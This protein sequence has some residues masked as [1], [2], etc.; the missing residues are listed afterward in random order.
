[1]ARILN[2]LSWALLAATG[3][4]LAGAGIL[5]FLLNR[6]LPDYDSSHAVQG[7][8]GPVEIVRDRHAI[9][10]IFGGTD[11]DVFFGLGFAHAQDRLWQMTLLRR[12]AH[13][14]LSEI[15][16]P[17]TLKTDRLMRMLDIHGLSVG[18]LEY[19]TGEARAALNAYSRGVN[20]W[21]RILEDRFLN[22]GAPEF[23]LFDST[24]RPWEPFDSIAILNL[25]AIEL[26]THAEDETLRTR[27]A[28]QLSPERMSDL[29]PADP[30][31]GLAIPFTSTV[32]GLSPVKGDGLFTQF[33]GNGF[34]GA[35]NAW[36]A[37]PSRSAD[38]TSL[39]ANDPH[40][41]LRA[42]S[43]WMLARLELSSGGVIGGTIPGVPLI[44][45]GRTA[46]TA[47]GVTSSYVDDQ[48][49]YF[50]QFDPETDTRYLTPD[51]SKEF[52]SRIEVIQIKD[53][54]PERIELKWTDNGP[55]VPEE[56]FGLVDIIPANHFASLA[57]TLLEPENRSIS[58]G[59]QLMKA[60]SVDEALEAANLHRAPT[61]NLLIADHSDIV[62]QVIGAAPRR[63][64]FHE[65]RG[66]TPSAGWK[67]HNRWQGEMSFESLPRFRNPANG[68]LANTNNKT[69]DRPF[70]DHLSL[71]WG[72]SQRIKRLEQLLATRESHTLESFTSIQLDTLSYPATT[73][74]PLFARELWHKTGI[75]PQSEIERLRN[76]A[77][78]QIS[79]W[80]GEM[81]EN[82]P[83]PLIYAAW[84]RTL[85]KLLLQDELGDLAQEFRKPDP[86]L[87]E[88][89]F[90]DVDGAA[91]L[92][93]I[94][95]TPRTESCDDISL[96]ALD[97]ALSQ[98]KERYGEELTAWRWGDAHQA[99]HDHP[100][101]GGD[102]LMSWLFSIRQSTSGGDY[103][104]NKA[105]MSGS[106]DEPYHNLHGAGYRGV[107]DFSD[108]DSSI[109]IIST[110]QSGHPLSRHFDDLGRL[111]R[112]GE[113]V[114]MS[115]D[116]DFARAN[117]IGITN[118]EPAQRNP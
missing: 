75:A 60:Q 3:L 31:T 50:E 16:G 94:V 78:E 34:R 13:G 40:L 44:A 98:L 19:Q 61:L 54:P 63:H 58:A 97:E 65:T 95:Q 114:L 6:S 38:K 46:K 5:Y 37:A 96:L 26:A 8:T 89:V 68:V 21:L 112:S 117:S 20:A 101:F 47:W 90:D 56:Y 91:E 45:I 59:I 7:I 92:C 32:A 17:A 100:V 108:L 88:R 1:M 93:D 71:A 74:V 113:Y 80:D 73:L 39:L 48:D 4:A 115:L 25:Q 55:A 62:M 49:L 51:G 27:A 103:T 22:D 35:S 30:G 84:A 111:W 106:G 66:M 102:N 43:I 82:I 33:T 79:D 11:E 76:E 69:I 24:V 77:I 41:R 87:L 110:G 42:P 29:M 36:A 57:W 15:F 52:R 53:Q 14:R 70:P 9:P 116:P 67:P 2:W 118:L 18:A 105:S 23:L 64:P 104:L 81:D 83:Q 99:R 10:H 85:Q 28:A 86:E 72:D 109:F 107:Y 12:A